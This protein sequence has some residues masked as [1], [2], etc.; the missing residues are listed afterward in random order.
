MTDM[1]ID[2]LISIERFLPVLAKEEQDALVIASPT[3]QQLQDW[4][5]RLDLRTKRIDG[6]FRRA[7]GKQN[8]RYR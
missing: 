1:D 6:I 3:L 5:H 7:F 8:R 2:T 4:Q